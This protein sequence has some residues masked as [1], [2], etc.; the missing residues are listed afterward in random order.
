MTVL[1]AITIQQPWAWA[2]AHGH[3]PIENRSRCPWK[4]GEPLLV[5][6]GGRWSK[7]GAHDERIARAVAADADAHASG[8]YLDIDRLAVDLTTRGLPRHGHQFPAGAILGLVD[9]LDAH[10]DAGCCRPW[11]ESLYAEGGGRIRTDVI[12]LVVANARPLPHPRPW[13]GQLGRWTVDGTSAD[14]ILE[15]L[16]SAA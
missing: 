16:A 5:H 4:V 9:L 10:P 3:K 14:A 12:H 6:A 11:G 8:A 2:V 13:P 15:Q 1:Q 7:R